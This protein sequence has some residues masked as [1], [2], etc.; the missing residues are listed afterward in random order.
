M[1][2]FVFKISAI[3]VTNVQE[4]TNFGNSKYS[5]V[6]FR[7]CEESRSYGIWLVQISIAVWQHVRRV[8]SFNC[9]FVT[10]RHACYYSIYFSI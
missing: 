2:D 9:S 8:G 7:F 10:K 1:F 5:S 6:L 3:S 4:E